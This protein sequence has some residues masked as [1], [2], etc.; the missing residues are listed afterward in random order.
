MNHAKMLF[1]GE[2][3]YFSGKYLDFVGEICLVHILKKSEKH[4]WKTQ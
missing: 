3:N 4:L 1:F 2:K